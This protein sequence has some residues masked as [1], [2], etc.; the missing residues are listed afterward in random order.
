M[1]AIPVLSFITAPEDAVP[2]ASDVDESFSCPIRMDI[3]LEDPN[4]RGLW[5]KAL[6]DLL[7][8]EFPH[9]RPVTLVLKQ[10]LIERTYGT[11]HTGGLCSYGLLLMVVG[12]L[13]H[14]P[15]ESPA[16]ALV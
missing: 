5:S 1:A 12:F 14:F 11:S 13:Q 9:A 4:H 7:L 2:E 10:W 3:S 6:I 15:A 8:R 16:A